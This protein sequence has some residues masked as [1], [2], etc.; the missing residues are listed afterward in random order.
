MKRLLAD[1]RNIWYV[2][3]ML[4]G[5]AAIIL[6][7]NSLTGDYSSAYTHLMDLSFGGD[8]YTEMYTIVND[9]RD[10][11]RSLDEIRFFFANE[12]GVT[13]I[14][15]GIIDICAF[16]SKI[17]LSKKEQSLENTSNTHQ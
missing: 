5:I 17:T 13:L 10:L 2:C 7:I 11:L 3:G 12:F 4:V 1:K 16:G 8:F 6:G 9:I 15:A 14:L